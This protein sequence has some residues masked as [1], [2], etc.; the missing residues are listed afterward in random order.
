VALQLADSAP[1]REFD[2]FGEDVRQNWQT[3][4]RDWSTSDPF[5]VLDDSGM[6]HLIVGRWE[7]VREGLQRWHD[8]TTIPPDGPGY[9]RHAMLKGIQ[10]VTHVEGEQHDALRRLMQP[11]F[12]PRRIDAYS[13]A[14]ERVVGALLDAIDERGGEFDAVT[15]FTAHLM[16]DMI[17]GEMLGLSREEMAPFIRRD[18]LVELFVSVPAGGETPPEYAQAL[19]DSVEVI[20]NLITRREQGELG[21]DFVSLMLKASRDGGDA[22]TREEIRDNFFILGIA[23]AT[24]QTTAAGALMM[25]CQNRGELDKLFADPSR[26]P[27]AAEECLRLH[28]G[29]HFPFTRFATRDTEIGGVSVPAGTPVLPAITAANRDPDRFEDPERL[30]IERGA[31]HLTF[32]VGTHF[33]M[34]SALARLVLHTALRRML[35]RFPD[36]E[37]VDPDF[38]PRYTG[39]LGELKPVSVPMRVR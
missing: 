25:L 12:A 30:D 37:L 33:C 24:T 29:G 1:V 2:L 15:D 34:G 14:A 20:E 17:M 22:V 39:Q 26:I 8:F 10:S 11:T 32:G 35:E 23:S 13:A 3:Y 21:D 4:A 31:K 36:I 6:P 27:D 5:F 18:E 19:A 28:P 16:R 7:H 9:E 38:R